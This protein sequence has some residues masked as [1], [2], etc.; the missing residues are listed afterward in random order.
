[1][2]SNITAVITSC[3]RHDLLK[4]TLDSFISMKTGGMKPEV[5]IIIEDGPTPMPD[6]LKENIHYYSSNVG[7]V[8]WIQN[9]G[10]M[11]QIY[12]IDRAYEQVK[13]DYI[14][15]CEDDWDF[16]QGN[17]ML[18]SKQI[19]EK[20]PQII[21]VSLRGDSGWHQ[22]ID[23]P[24]LEGFKVAM[25]Y[26][27][28]CWGGL[29]FNPGLRRLSDYKRI[30]SYGRHTSYGTSGLG[31][32]REL[33]QKMLDMGYLI[34]DLNRV[35]VT[36]TG[37]A[38]SRAVEPLAAL[39][40]ILIAIPVC[41]KM[42]YGKWESANSPHFNPSNAYNG[43]AYGTDIHISGDN[44]RI[45][46]LRDTWLKDIEPF[47]AHV[48]YKLFYGAPHTRPALE[49]EIY[50][51]CPD[52]YE[53]L[54]HKTIA[55]CKWAIDKDY[56]YIFKCDDDTGVY[57][58]RLIKELMTSRFDYAGFTHSNVCTGG[59]GYWLSRR[60][61]TEVARNGA[62]AHWAEDVTV[63]KSM[64]AANIY[65]IH[66]DGHRTGKSDHWFWKDGY[67]PAVDMSGVSTFHAVRPSDMRA[68]YANLKEK[69]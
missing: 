53:H 21:Q 51:D 32:E 6:W 31:H 27:H 29:A 30:G 46:A 34:A 62:Q 24:P 57:V 19:L 4:S 40:K 36:H 59:T 67:D 3:N 13:T 65:P 25:P 18:E 1:M 48:S 60:A 26:W 42:D 63:G 9:E 10:R 16:V 56:S 28:G 47:K 35:I 64:G 44:D 15:H 49:D 12:S 17:F 68:W 54:P 7:T 11:G 55:I 33:S 61:F 14:F 66:L 38:R 43:S 52:D 58:D 2:G 8:K 22:L 45:A 69:K 23:K 5:C 39:P 37:G 20:Y 50:L 41:H